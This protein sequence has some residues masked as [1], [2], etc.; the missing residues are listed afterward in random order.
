[1]TR[2]YLRASMILRIAADV[3]AHEIKNFLAAVGVVRVARTEKIDKSSIS[4]QD[5][6]R[7]NRL[8]TDIERVRC[9][10]NLAS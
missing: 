5:V 9:R 7:M 10:A 6:A 4:R 1:M 2:G 3:G 8:I